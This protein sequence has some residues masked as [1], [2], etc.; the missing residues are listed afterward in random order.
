MKIYKKL[1]LSSLALL[2]VFVPV[3]AQADEED[4]WIND[5]VD[6]AEELKRQN[7]STNAQL[8]NLRS[9]YTSLLRERAKTAPSILIVSPKAGTTITASSS[10]TI[11]WRGTNLSGSTIDIDLINA[12]NPAQIINL[13]TATPNDGE[14]AINLAA[15]SGF[16]RFYLR[17]KATSGVATTQMKKVL[18]LKDP[19]GDR[20]IQVNN[21][22]GGFVVAGQ[23]TTTLFNTNNL[24]A[25]TR[26]E[27]FLVPGT[28]TVLTTAGGA[29]LL[30][31]VNLPASAVKSATYS[32][33]ITVPRDFGTST[34]R[35]AVAS[36]ATQNASSTVGYSAPFEVRGIPAEPTRLTASCV[37]N[38]ATLAAVGSVAEWSVT[39]TGGVDTKTYA[40][41]ARN[42]EIAA[43][44][45]GSTTLRYTIPNPTASTGTIDPSVR[46]T[47]GTQTVNAGCPP[48]N[49]IRSST[50]PA[51]PAAP[52]ITSINVSQ[53]EPG[54]SVTIT[55]T[56]LIAGS[57][58]V[59]KVGNNTVREVTSTQVTAST[60]ISFVVPAIDAKA[61]SIVVT[62]PSGTSASRGFRVL[63]SRAIQVLTAPTDVSWA[64]GKTYSIRWKDTRLANS[65][66]STFISLVP[67]DASSTLPTVAI[68]S[69]FTTNDGT[70]SYRVP[71]SVKNGQYKLTVQITQNGSNGVDV[72]T[73]ESVGKISISG[74]SN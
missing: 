19:S 24:P 6:R 47:S 64:A 45:N 12:Q 50:A 65:A 36:V 1:L 7:A 55:G 29:R 39:T 28:S 51:T 30:S 42:Y 72:Y 71:T 8:N 52:R 25:N 43:A 67:A 16:G 57:K 34:V 68:T 3:V 48:V 56:D 35:L 46:V 5:I 63:A 14:E 66:R 20:A 62:N 60:S 59:F 40:W 11:K 33:R 10:V 9:L 70:F 58:V 53:A 27:F 32:Q 49:F 69:T 2:L 31:S 4:E 54:T 13:A 26:L 73:G 23:A 15:R 17:I 74:G 37:L 44:A 38:T 18:V 21:P 41:S 61:Y 22:R